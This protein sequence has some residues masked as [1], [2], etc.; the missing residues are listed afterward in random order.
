MEIM[1]KIPSE[2][3]CRCCG[4]VKPITEFAID[5]RSKSRRQSCCKKCRNAQAKKYRHAKKGADP[6]EA[7]RADA[8]EKARLAQRNWRESNRARVIE[9]KRRWMKN[10]PEKVAN[11]KRNVY[12]RRREKLLSAFREA[13]KNLTDVYVRGL[14]RK[15][16]GLAVVEIPAELIALKREQVLLKRLAKQLNHEITNQLEKSNES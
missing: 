15:G 4:E 7:L 12:K 9:L 6:T 8:S 14:L 5:K 16:G 3:F 11:G 10:N 2:K 13:A 1:E